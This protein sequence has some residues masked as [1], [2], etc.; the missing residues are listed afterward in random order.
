[1]LV[2]RLFSGDRTHQVT[3]NNSR[4]GAY[5]LR[6]TLRRADSPQVRETGRRWLLVGPRSQEGSQEGQ[7]LK[8]GESSEEAEETRH[9]NG[10]P[11]SSELERLG[12]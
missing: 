7:E 9:R 10:I 2:E 4:G 5:A 11:P 3:A 12:Q 6:K 8:E 1:M